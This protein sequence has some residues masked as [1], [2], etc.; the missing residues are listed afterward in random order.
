[1]HDTFAFDRLVGDSAWTRRTRRRIL[2]A[3]SYSYPV[4]ITGPPGSGKQLVARAIHA[5]D[6]RCRGPFI[7]FLCAHVPDSL[8]ASQLFGHTAG[9]V[10][11]TPHAALGCVCAAQ[12]G[13]L[14]L[15]EIGSLDA[16]C[17]ARLLSLLKAHRFLPGGQRHA[18]PGWL[19]IIASASVDLH[20]EV[21][22]G[23]FSFELLYRLNV[24]TVTVAGLKQRRDDIPALVRHLIARTTLEHGLPFKQVTA[25][26]M[27]LLQA[28]DWPGNVDELE[29]VVEQAVALSDEPILG[30]E[31]FPEI[32][33][34]MDC[35]PAGRAHQR[36]GGVGTGQRPRVGSVLPAGRQAVANPGAGGS[37][38]HTS[39]SPT[40]PLPP[41]GRCAIARTGTGSAARKNGSLRDP[42][43]HAATSPRRPGRVAL[44]DLTCP[45]STLQSP[46]AGPALAAV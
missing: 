34:A 41:T 17:Q 1:M 46:G 9:T 23:R 25:S 12:G 19:R 2:Q 33:E 6:P 20:H 42:A 36:R 40:G 13:T 4:L 7:P 38:S 21:Q 22:A 35:A 30:P 44:N 39:H 29:Q 32:L 18:T 27:A 11:L 3:A 37:R 28:W 45:P 31:A 14:Y 10:S 24:L 8:C 15:D 5:H 16:D 26:A 43:P